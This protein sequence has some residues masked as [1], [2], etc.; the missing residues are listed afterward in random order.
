MLLMAVVFTAGTTLPSMFV[1]PVAEALRVG[2]TQVTVNI[3][4]STISSMLT[5][6]FAG[7]YLSQGKIRRTMLVCIT[8]NAAAFMGYSLFQRIGLFYMASAV[9]GFCTTMLCSLP[10]P[11]LIN[12][13]FENRIRGRVTA[14]AMA[15]SGIG[16]MLLH[17]LVGYINEYWGWQY[18]FRLL[19]CVMLLVVL[20]AIAFTVF[21]SPA[22]KGLAKAD[23]NGGETETQAEHEA[24]HEAEHG[25]E[26]S[27]M[28]AMLRNR[29]FQA[30]I[31]I[32]LLFGLIT[33][34]YN[35]NAVSYFTDAGLTQLQAAAMIS[36]SS[37][38]G[39]A[40]KLLL[41]TASDKA[42]IKR[43]IATGAVVL[44]LGTGCML[45]VMISPGFVFP[46]AVLLGMG[47]ALPTVG[48][49]LLIAHL[50]GDEAF[51][52]LIGVG[53]MFISLGAVAG[54]LMGSAVFDASGSY[55]FAWVINLF[56]IGSVWVL[57][58]LPSVNKAI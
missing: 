57:S 49:P 8:I 44:L 16:A 7:R 25:A 4:I 10:V 48:A 41:G 13:W 31:L 33:S 58:R 9:V 54:S 37:A 5:A 45:A 55:A 21:D 12:N 28:S 26:R 24:E 43:G 29:V 40:G 47:N 19:S 15:G 22:I 34:L 53:Q 42:G 27:G 46:S 17:P 50:F 39:I 18:S 2:R 36:V 6:A 1:K 23:T 52:T 11:M 3:T 56:F 14:I 51:G 38:M 30:M 20:P 35:V 32:C